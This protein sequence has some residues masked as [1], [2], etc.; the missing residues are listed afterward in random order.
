MQFECYEKII[1]W[2]WF[3]GYKLPT[4]IIKVDH[5]GWMKKIKETLIIFLN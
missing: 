2:I 5:N 3:I 4:T 1:T